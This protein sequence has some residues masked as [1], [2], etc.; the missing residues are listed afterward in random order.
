MSDKLNIKDFLIIDDNINKKSSL[1]Y[2]STYN[3]SNTY[4]TSLHMNNNPYVNKSASQ[5]TYSSTY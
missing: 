3:S 4:T 5:Y 2:I 1:Q